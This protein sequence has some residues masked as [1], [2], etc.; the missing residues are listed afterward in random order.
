MDWVHIKIFTHIQDQIGNVGVT[1][2]SLDHILVSYKW[3]WFY[4]GIIPGI[5]P[6]LP[7]SFV[8]D[9]L[10]NMT[11]IWSLQVASLS[12]LPSTLLLVPFF[13]SADMVIFLFFVSLRWS[14]LCQPDCALVCLDIRLN[15]ISG[16]VCGVF[17][18]EISMWTG[19]LRK[20]DCIPECEWASLNPRRAWIE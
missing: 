15:I 20:G 5:H 12:V 7:G 17:L 2:F 14:T 19:S 1:F 9:F 4:P 6:L 13:L 16:L 18:G 8:S 11:P 10:T 3:C